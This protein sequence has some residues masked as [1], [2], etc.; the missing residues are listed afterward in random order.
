MMDMAS[1]RADDEIRRARALGDPTRHRIFEHLCASDHNLDVV[2]L[3]ALIGCHHNAVRQHLAKL[4]KAG[5]V[6][7][8]PRGP[9]GRGRPRIGYQVDWR[10][11]GQ[12]DESP[13]YEQLAALLAE[14]VRT[15]S[16]ARAAGRRAGRRLVHEHPS[17]RE[18]PDAV[19]EIRATT[20]RL[21]FAPDI[22]RGDD[23]VELVL[24]HCPFGRVAALEPTTVC[25]LHLGLVEG[26]A[27]GLGGIRVRDL[28]VADPAVAG[29]RLVL[30]QTSS[31]PPTHASQALSRRDA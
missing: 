10:A 1:N 30:E 6:V 26:M 28:V 25:G 31:A 2:E 24:R 19:A 29:C 7:E 12:H 5:L 22:E 15:R 27:K 23:T 18:R 16:S 17:P 20:E 14:A 11:G 21:G 9:S 4:R 3:T 13:A 8:V